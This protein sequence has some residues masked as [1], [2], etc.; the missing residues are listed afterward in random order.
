MGKSNAVFLALG[1]FLGVVGCK[2][3][4]VV[5]NGLCAVHNSIA[6]MGRPMLYHFASTF[7]S[8]GLKISRLQSGKGDQLRWAAE[9]GK[10]AKFRKDNRGRSYTDSGNGQQR[11][12]KP[13]DTVIDLQ[14]DFSTLLWSWL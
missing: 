11:R 2:H 12:S 4:L 6:Q 8:T 3:R 10:I 9:F 1:T 5:N 7:R 13:K 14:L